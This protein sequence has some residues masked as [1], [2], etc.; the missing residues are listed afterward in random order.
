MNFINYI[1]M[2]SQQVMMFLGRMNNPLTNKPEK[3]LEAAKTFIDI[4][5][6]LEEKTQGNLTDE[7][8]SY[9]TSTLNNLR[10][11]YVEDSKESE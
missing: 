2:L 9:L 4:I 7:E 1:A 11:Y 3:N 5:A 6:M 8:K 10:M